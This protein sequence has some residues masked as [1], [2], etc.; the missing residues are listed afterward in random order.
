[1]AEGITKEGGRRIAV[2]AVV[3][4]AAV[5]GYY[6]FSPVY[7]EAALMKKA[8]ATEALIRA[9][10]AG[11][12]RFE[13]VYVEATN[14][15]DLGVGIEMHGRSYSVKDLRELEGIVDGVTSPVPVW[16]SITAPTATWL[17]VEIAATPTKDAASTNALPKN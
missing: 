7:K 16:W 8:H 6:P 2:I 3:G 10:I 9:R 15:S 13:Q 14:Y 4:I 12:P 1:M 5:L 11:C 17:A